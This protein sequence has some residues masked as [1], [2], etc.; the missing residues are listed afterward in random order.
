M[1][2]AR[3]CDQ[4]LLQSFALQRAIL[5]LP[6]STPFQLQQ[7]LDYLGVSAQ[8]GVHQSTLATLINMIHLA[9]TQDSYNYCTETGNMPNISGKYCMLQTADIQVLTGGPMLLIMNQIREATK[10]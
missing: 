6:L 10:A 3:A 4:C 7:V 5:L 1:S 2:H 8:C 9:G